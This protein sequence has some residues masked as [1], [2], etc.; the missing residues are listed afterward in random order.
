MR[1]K[2]LVQEHNTMTRPGL[3]RAPLDPVSGTLTIRSPRRMTVPVFININCISFCTK[4]FLS[5]FSFTARDMI[6]DLFEIPFCDTNIPSCNLK[7]WLFDFKVLD[8]HSTRW[9]TCKFTRTVLVVRCD[10]DLIN[11]W[12]NIICYRPRCP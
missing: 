11:L 10:E 3:E 8:S 12:N 4:N 1:V 7:D 6:I 2:C 5:I 9:V